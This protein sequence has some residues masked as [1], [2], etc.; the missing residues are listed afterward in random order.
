[1]QSIMD[2]K[3]RHIWS[4]K[5]KPPLIQMQEEHT[6]MQDVR[7]SLKVKSL[8]WKIEKRIL[9]RIGHIL[10]MEDTRQVKAVTLGWLED[11]EG[12]EKMPGKKRK[13]ILYWKRLL[14]QAGI[15]WTRIEGLTRDRKE[16]KQLVRDRMKHLE[17]W[18][19]RGGN[20]VEEERGERNVRVVE[21]ETFIC[22][23]EGCRKICKSKAGL[24]IHRKRIHEKSSQKVI[25]TCVRC[26]ETFTQDANLQ[27]HRKA[28]TGLRALDPDKKT[29]DVC[30]KTY[31]KKNFK[32]HR[33]QH[34]NHHDQNLQQNL[35]QPARVYK[36]KYGPCPLCSTVVSLTNLSRHQKGARCTGGAA[37]H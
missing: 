3:Y 27:N 26:M 19:R 24:T 37:F 7:N 6:N 30:N 20:K 29:C 31:S 36:P 13:T 15:D 8:R 33:D 16:W 12:K 18:E 23:Y 32:R 11:L 35:Q 9:E 22:E 2:R 21:E 5:S 17:E 10:R 34:F 25:F 28:C 14:K 4:N 1:M